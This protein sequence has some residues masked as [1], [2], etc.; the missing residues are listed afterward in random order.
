MTHTS[1][2]ITNSDERALAAVAHFFGALVALI[3]WATQKDKS[4]FIRFQ[5]IQALAFDV[6]IVLFTMLLFGCIFAASMCA[7]LASMAVTIALAASESQASNLFGILFFLPTM[8]PLALWLPMMF[9]GTSLFIV[10]IVAAASVLQGRDFRYPW[11]GQQV[12]KFLAG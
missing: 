3:V 5:A 10:R 4:P 9:Y 6:T 8:I 1:D 11:L 12:E 2:P 7:M